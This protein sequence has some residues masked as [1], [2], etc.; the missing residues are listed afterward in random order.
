M[1]KNKKIKE[2]EGKFV[3]SESSEFVDSYS[4]EIDK[5]KINVNLKKTDAGIIYQLN[6]PEL[7]IGTIAL[8]E[9]IK[10]EL[11]DISRFSAE[12][13]TDQK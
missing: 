2:K 10:K 11:I 1:R 13:I 3:K 12:D 8:L 4:I 7:G 6:I 5:A 9:E